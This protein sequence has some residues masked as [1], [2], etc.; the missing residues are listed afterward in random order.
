MLDYDV[1]K[2]LTGP[3][4]PVGETHTDGHRY[5]NLRGTIELIELLL[6]DI[7]EVA[8]S[9]SRAGLRAARFLRKTEGELKEH[10]E[11]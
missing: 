1:V 8:H 6:V 9:M 7:T 11:S 2:K 5:E 3:I 10:N 4:E